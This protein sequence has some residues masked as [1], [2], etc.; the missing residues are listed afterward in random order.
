MSKSKT[1]FIIS[2]VFLNNLVLGIIHNINTSAIN[3]V[4]S[5]NTRLLLF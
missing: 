3:K 1:A 5:Y 4:N 2:V